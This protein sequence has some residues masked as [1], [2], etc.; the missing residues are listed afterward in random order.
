MALTRDMDRLFE[1]MFSPSSRLTPVEI[2]QS[3]FSA[4][5]NISE[6]ENN[7]YVE[8]ELPGVKLEDIEILAM[9]EELTV[10]GSREIN[11]PEGS[12]WLRRERSAGSFERK[13]TLPS[14]INV[15]EVK[16]E[17]REGVLTITLPKIEARRP[18]R[19]TVKALAGGK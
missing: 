17:L 6:D 14:E 11:L 9:P 5:L 15:D 13:T 7:V 8:T 2:Q 18:K 19:I 16:A 1:S 10:K 12:R 3:W 4:P